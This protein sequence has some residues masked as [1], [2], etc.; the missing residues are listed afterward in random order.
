VE[1]DERIEDWDVSVTLSHQ[2]R[3][4][5]EMTVTKTGDAGGRFDSEL[6]V[7]PYFTFTRRCDGKL[8][9]LD[10]GEFVSFPGVLDALRVRSRS[11]PWLH[12]AAGALH[13]EGLNE[14]FVAGAPGMFDEASATCIHR[15]GEAPSCTV[16]ISLTGTS[17]CLCL[18]STRRFTATGSPS[19]GKY[20]WTIVRGGARATIVSGANSRTVT[21]RGESVSQTVND[22]TLRVDYNV[23]MAGTCSAELTLTTI[24]VTFPANAFRATGSL[25]SR[26]NTVPPPGVGG[27]RLGA[28]SPDNPAGAQGYFQKVEIRAVVEP[29]GVPLPCQFRFRQYRQGRTGF[30]IGQNFVPETKDCP[31]PNWCR[32][33]PFFGLGQDAAPFSD[34]SIFMVDG[35]GINLSGS[36][37]C[38]TENEVILLC[39]NFQVWVEADGQKCSDDFFW[40]SAT[41]IRCNGSRLVLDN[42]PGGNDVG[43][44]SRPECVMSTLPPV[45]DFTI[46]RTL[47]LLR[48]ESSHDRILGAFLVTQACE[49]ALI[50]D[51]DR[52][53]L[54]QRLIESLGSGHARPIFHSPEEIAISLLGLLR[55]EE[56]VDVLIGQL[57]HR[58]PRISFSFSD[59]SP[60]TLAASALA[61]IGEPSIRALVAQADSSDDD[62]W[63]VSEIALRLIDNQRAVAVAACDVLDRRNDDI[64]ARRL[65]RYLYG[66]H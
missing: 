13:I 4:D 7:V 35:P 60:S 29:A 47:E 43:Q 57:L 14:N 3:S 33:D 20:Q 49:S 30:L 37:F 58:F 32:D 62:R 31:F 59:A 38:N 40:F 25:D 9:T 45:F 61:C 5:G 65:G 41:R 15:V 48:A 8:R 54:I 53:V 50:T 16:S 1:I 64:G 52:S 19:G 21:V 22:I 2:R 51:D 24:R 10:V 63:T 6:V 28:I 56:A 23:A 44:G 39:M 42:F 66:R 55:A 36:V 34:G 11:T 12:S 27:Q 18:G 46:G 26:N 17:Q